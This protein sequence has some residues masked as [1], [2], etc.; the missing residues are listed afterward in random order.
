VLARTGIDMARLKRDEDSHAGDIEAVL[1]HNDAEAH[2]SNIAGTP[3]IVIG[4]KV[5][6]GAFDLD[7]LK[8][9]IAAARRG[10]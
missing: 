5:L 1:L 2:A 7:G 10:R 6:S 9:S 3:G 8:R 4:R